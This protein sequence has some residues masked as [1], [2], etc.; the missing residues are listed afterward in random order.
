MK[1]K[2]LFGAALLLAAAA[3]AVAA[4]LLLRS[5]FARPPRPNIVLI[6]IDTLRAD[7]LGCYG[8]PAGISPHIDAFC[9]ESVQFLRAS[10]QAPSTTGSHMS[11]FTGLLPAVHRVTNWVLREDLAKRF[12][13]APLAAGIPTLAQYLREN[14]YR[15]V[16]LHGGGHVAP[17]FGFDRGFDLYSDAIID[18]GKFY[19]SRAQQGGLL[20][21]LRTARASKR[22]YFLFLHHYLCHEPYLA[23]PAWVRQRFLPDPE[24]GLPLDWDGV[25]PGRGLFDKKA[26]PAAAADNP[27]PYTRYYETFWKKIDDGNP[28]HRRHVRALYDSGVHYA[29]MVLGRIVEL[30]KREGMYDQALIVVLSDH[31]EEFW[32]HG[33]IVHRNLFKETLH[34]PLLVRFPG[35]EFGGRRVKSPVGQ[36][37]LMPT[38][39]EYLR[40]K[41]RLRLQAR[42][43]LPLV[44]AEKEP[45]RRVISFSDGA[46]S[47]RFHEGPFVYSDQAV[48]K[49]WGERLYNF[50]F[51]PLEKRNIIAGSPALQARMRALAAGIMREQLGLRARIHAGPAKG[52]AISPA[53]RKQL[54]TLGYL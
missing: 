12:D 31:G 22:P 25:M 7:R 44:R 6:S 38:I 52:S 50:Y 53:L 51:D 18:W 2:H 41:P 20:S 46:D 47:L 1:K 21:R 10:S 5:R 40:I 45:P 48:E 19:S 49:R 3:L 11:L 33:G 35:G 17:F 13:L 30:L 15:T 14:G 24:P 16:G 4:A 29:D 39:L 34:V 54:E 37:D 27:K 23:A 8:G 9:G 42:S 28:R 36:F 26:L 43:L 32:E